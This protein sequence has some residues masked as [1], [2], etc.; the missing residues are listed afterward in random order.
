MEETPSRRL[1]RHVRAPWLETLLDVLQTAPDAPTDPVY[2]FKDP[3]PGD[4]SRGEIL[5]SNEADLFAA[6]GPEPR[7]RELAK[8]DSRRIRAHS[9]AWL[10]DLRSLGG[11]AAR[12]TARRALT[13][14]LQTDHRGDRIAWR[15]D[16][17]G[18]RLVAWMG[19]Y[20]FF[21]AS[22]G[23]SFRSNL[24]EQTAVHTAWLKKRI[25]QVSPGSGRFSAI[26]GL[27]AGAVAVG[28]GDKYF[29]VIDGIFAAACRDDI[30]SD[31]WV[32]NA[33]PIDQLDTLMR[34]L[35]LRAA[36]NAVG[37]QFRDN[38]FEVISAVSE[39]VSVLRAGNGG[40]A[41]FSGGEGDP[42]AV[43][44]ALASSG[45]RGRAVLDLPNAG[46]SRALAGRSSAVLSAR[47][48]ALEFSHGSDRILVSVGSISDAPAPRYQSDRASVFSAPIAMSSRFLD[49]NPIERVTDEGA[50][51]LTA[52][53]RQARPEI[54]WKRRIFLA[55][56]GFDLRGEDFMET[57]SK[58]EGLV[59]FHLHPSADAIQI[60]ET[61]ALIR[62]SSGQGWRLRADQPIQLSPEPYRGLPGA[63][64]AGLRI[65]FSIYPGQTRRWAIRKETTS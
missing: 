10:R 37:W 29:S 52:S 35:D 58:V 14:W 24:M 30:G 12:Q 11:D 43:D 55:A 16:V 27:A 53:Y 9:F 18:Q 5:I 31:G 48:G 41:V 61:S 56:D 60:D 25:G 45:W 15:I 4:A 3:W 63:P 1:S 22:A 44:L 54:A 8:D 36:A 50:S 26:A 39:P 32:T 47:N 59:P 20:D 40:L 17:V 64:A 57:R 2:R 34:L 42:W 51:L 65:E 23:P 49:F 21:A 38:I 13:T 62:T 28:A 7:D 6:L 33:S 46:Y 19:A